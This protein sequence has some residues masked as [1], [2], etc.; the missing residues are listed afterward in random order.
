MK[1]FTLIELIVSVAIFTVVMVI[2][3]G[4]LLAVSAGE[5]KAETLKSVMDNLNFTLESMTRSIRTGYDYGCPTTNCTN[6]G[7]KI[8]F[9]SSEGDVNYEYCLST[10]ATSNGCSTS[11]TCPALATGGTCRILRRIAE[12]TLFTPMTAS[13]VN[14]KHFA[15][16]VR[17]APIGSADDT[18]SNVVITLSGTV[19]VSETQTSDFN[20]QTSVTQ[21]LYDS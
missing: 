9:T 6:G 18:Q 5:R 10:D 1:G 13:E 8:I 20:L 21:R 4:A 15:F 11:T 14:I 19:K 12:E 7:P 2:A 3:V 16:Y 17:G